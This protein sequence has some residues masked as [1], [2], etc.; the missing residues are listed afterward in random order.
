[1]IGG[2]I[3]LVVMEVPPVSPA[4]H[5]IVVKVAPILDAIAGIGAG[6]RLRTRHTGHTGQ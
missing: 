2:T 3:A 1:M 5:P 4:I 6:R